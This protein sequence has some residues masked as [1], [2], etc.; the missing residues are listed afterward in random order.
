MRRHAPRLIPG[1]AK[2]LRICA[3]G[4]MPSLVCAGEPSTTHFAPWD[5]EQYRT[6]LVALTRADDRRT[7]I[8]IFCTQIG[9]RSVVYAYDG[10]GQ[11][12]EDIPISEVRIR[13]TPD[14]DLFGRSMPSSAAT[15]D[16]D[17]Y[18]IRMLLPL[19]EDF[20]APQSGTIS[21]GSGPH[22]P[23]DKHWSVTID[24]EGLKDSVQVAFNNCV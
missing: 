4:L 14:I 24:T 13:M 2:L 5:V 11:A 22:T 10:R 23:Q 16:N 3:A 18:I 7:A 15:F 12:S 8:L 21:I 6:G 1:L 19:P 17:G 9:T 20:E